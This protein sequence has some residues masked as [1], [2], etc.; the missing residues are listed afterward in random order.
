MVTH[1]SGIADFPDFFFTEDNGQFRFF[2][3]S[4]EFEIGPVT[5]ESDCVEEFDASERNSLA[6]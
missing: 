1:F 2:L 4:Y 3:R 6:P 5:F